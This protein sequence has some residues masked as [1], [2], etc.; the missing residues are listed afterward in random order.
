MFLSKFLNG[1]QG[2][3]T[4]HSAGSSVS[5]IFGTGGDAINVLEEYN[6][7]AWKLINIRA[8]TLS[9]EDLFVEKLVGNKWVEDTTH[10]FNDVMEGDNGRRDISE[11]LEASSRS[12]DLYGEYFWYFSKGEKYNKP[13]SI[14]LLNPAYVTVLVRDET[15]VG[16]VYQNGTVR[17][18][19]DV[20]EVLHRRIEDPKSPFRGY[21][22]MQAAGWFIKSSRYTVT[23]VNNFLENN[24][25]PAGVVVAKGT[26]NDSDWEL[27][28]EQWAAKYGGVDNS[29]KT[30]YIR[31]SDLDFVKTGL[32]LGDIDVEK[33]RNSSLQDVLFMFGVSKPMAAIFDEMN[34]ANAAVARELFAI[35]HT[36]PELKALTRKLTKKV[37]GWYGNQYRVWST[38]PV[39]VDEEAKLN[40]YDKGVGRWITVNEARADYGLPPI[41]GGDVIE[42]AKSTVATEK[43]SKEGAT[44]VFLDKTRVVLKAE[45]PFD[46]EK[47]RKAVDNNAARAEKQLCK[48]L[49]PLLEEQRDRRLDAVEPK[50]AVFAGLNTQEE[51][52]KIAEAAT[53]ILVNLAAEQGMLAMGITGS[54][55]DFDLT[56]GIRSYIKSSIRQAAL[57][58]TEDTE[59]LISEAISTG[60]E[61]GES[62]A[63]LKAR[64]GKIYE[65][66]TGYEAPGY[67]LERLVRYETIKASGEAAERSYEQSGVVSQKEWYNNPGACE[68]CIA[69][70]G[71]KTGL[72]GTFLAKGDT[73]TVK[74]KT[75]TSEYENVMHEPLHV[76]CRCTTLPVID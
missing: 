37:R 14:Y 27:F 61:A 52:E 66:A 40:K 60:L 16:Y 26:V 12:L 63:E 75:Y 17:A 24:A 21:G 3:T 22:P 71:N 39:P 48:V 47:Y 74:G 45:R 18:T 20:D 5:S 38:N 31:G 67:R 32:S 58:F 35:T 62:V 70:N 41:A 43:H 69:M 76:N 25:I 6:G 55:K 33:I 28:K 42:P 68:F 13:H 23:Y 2:P 9:S 50:K 36:R 57:S 11:L 73:I 46:A 10:E 15:V 19:L 65:D 49:S 8:T 53:S 54:D 29:G 4:L 56:E 72:G 1:S 30:G 59:R 44:N 34:R 51:S 7:Y 64:I